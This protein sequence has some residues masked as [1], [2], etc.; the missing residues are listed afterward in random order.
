MK[1]NLKKCILSTLWNKLKEHYLA[2]V[3]SE[4]TDEAL[5]ISKTKI[6]LVENISMMSPAK[7]KLVKSEVNRALLF[8]SS[9]LSDNEIDY[10]ID[11]L[12]IIE[13]RYK[14]VDIV[15]LFANPT[16]VNDSLKSKLERD[17][18][19]VSVHSIG[20]SPELQDF[21]INRELANDLF[22]SEFKN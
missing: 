21:E 4:G 1:K 22:Y 8:I 13:P 20:S 14:Y 9:L 6:S 2:R 10:T 3:D 16:H 7:G 18:I 12:E 19:I 17:D 11:K 5:N 15:T